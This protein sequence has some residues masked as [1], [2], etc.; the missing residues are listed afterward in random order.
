[1]LKQKI[2]DPTFDRGTKLEESK[3]NTNE[4]SDLEEEQIAAKEV[5]ENI[6]KCEKNILTEKFI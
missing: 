3:I 6:L 1:M 2:I 5:E 4:G